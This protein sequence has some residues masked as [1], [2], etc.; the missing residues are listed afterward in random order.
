MPALKFNFPIRNRIIAGLALGTVIIEAA[1]NSG[2]LLTAAAAI[3]YNREVFAVPGPIF[4]ETSQGTNRL[5]KMGAKLVIS[6]EDI[7]EELDIPQKVS[8]ARAREIIGD[9]KEEEILLN[10]LKEPQLIDALV[11]KSGLDSSIINATIIQME[12]KGKIIN[13]GGTRYQIKGLY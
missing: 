3:E 6:A 12:I 11:V 5:I 1:E 13:L 2:S 7:L 9:T 8:Q 4:S 10:L